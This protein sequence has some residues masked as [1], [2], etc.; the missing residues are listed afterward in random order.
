MDAVQ[1]EQALQAAARFHAYFWQPLATHCSGEGEGKGQGDGADTL[2]PLPPS[3]AHA[4]AL[5]LEEKVWRRG[6]WWRPELRP[7]LVDRLVAGEAET[8]LSALCATLPE[9]AHIDLSSPNKRDLLRAAITDYV[10]RAN[11]VEHVSAAPATSGV[12]SES[13]RTLVHGDF[14]AANLF[15]PPASA[16]NEALIDFQWTGGACSG[17]ADVVYLI[18]G[19]RFE[20]QLPLIMH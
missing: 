5:A 15:L 1:A 3:H 4:H 2:A 14:K 16:C 18:T 6:C 11:L 19:V 13:R 7:G 10:T 9:C 8:A 17:A 20:W 12:V